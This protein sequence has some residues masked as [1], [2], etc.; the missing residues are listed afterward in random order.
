MTG[1]STDEWIAVRRLCG[2]LLVHL[3]AAVPKDTFPFRT[4][5]PNFIFPYL[6]MMITKCTDQSQEAKEP[7]VVAGLIE[8]RAATLANL[9]IPDLKGPLCNMNE[10]AS[11]IE[12]FI[13]LL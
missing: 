4:L 7:S 8:M 3:A 2:S 13:M 5:L 9:G 11:F 10:Q 6:E 1:P 12:W